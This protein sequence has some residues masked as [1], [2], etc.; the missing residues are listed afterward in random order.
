MILTGCGGGQNYVPGFASDRPPAPVLTNFTADHTVVPYGQSVNLSWMLSGSY[1][2]SLWLYDERNGTGLPI[3]LNPSATTLSFIPHGRQPLELVATNNGGASS[4][5]LTLVSLGV[6][7]CTTNSISFASV[8]AKDPLGIYY[9]V[10]ASS[11]GKIYKFLISPNEFMTSVFSNTP[12][13]TSIAWS[14]YDGCLL[15]TDGSKLMRLFWDGTVTTAISNFPYT[16]M[17]VGKDGTIYSAPSGSSFGHTITVTHPNGTTSTITGDDQFFPS[18][19]LVLD[20][21]ESNLYVVDG[22]SGTATTMVNGISTSTITYANTIHRID[23]SSFTITTIAGQFNVPGHDDGI[24]TDATFN[25]IGQATL[26]NDGVTLYFCDTWNGLIRKIDLTT[27]QV[28]TVAGTLLPQPYSLPLNAPLWQPGSNFA[29]RFIPL[30][31]VQSINGDLIFSVNG[32]YTKNGSTY[33]DPVPIAVV[34]Q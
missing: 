6:D 13:V 9:A 10:D 19:G 32:S 33:T 4:S 14:K 31:I 11:T 34:T 2:N 8:M 1:I 29:A 26:S 23:L 21:E 24:G 20:A 3:I 27:Y 18:G 12:N 15:L 28:S 22:I 7:T 25:T 16:T 5:S 17:T 30:G